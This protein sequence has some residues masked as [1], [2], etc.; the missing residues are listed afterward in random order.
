MCLKGYLCAGRCTVLPPWPWTA[1]HVAC[2]DPSIRVCAVALPGSR[3]AAGAT[4]EADTFTTDEAAHV[5]WSRPHA[6]AVGPEWVV[7]RRHH[8]LRGHFR[9]REKGRLGTRSREQRA[10]D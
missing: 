1:R 4:D 5:R 8:G 3:L 7:C 6:R 2:S 10:C 9:P